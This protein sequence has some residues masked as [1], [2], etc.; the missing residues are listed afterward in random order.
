MP[1]VN[2]LTGKKRRRSTN[3]TSRNNRSLALDAYDSMVVRALHKR[4]E[5]LMELLCACLVVA[6]LCMLSWSLSLID[7]DII[8]VIT[9]SWIALVNEM[10]REIV[11]L[12]ALDS[13]LVDL[14]PDDELP[15][16]HSCRPRRHCSL[17]D[18]GSPE[19]VF[20][21]TNFMPD[22]IRMIMQFLQIPEVYRVEVLFIVLFE[23]F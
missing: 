5:N 11:H 9:L 13:Q 1:F 23:F 8:S 20:L 19:Q 3:R 18:Y 16:G 12:F 10:N 22:D 7:D 2:P 14:D 4:I 6:S 15:R 21:D 17:D